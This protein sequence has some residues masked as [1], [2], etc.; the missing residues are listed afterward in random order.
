MTPAVCTEIFMEFMKQILYLRGQIPTS[1]EQLQKFHAR[2]QGKSRL[3]SKELKVFHLIKTVNEC[4]ESLQKIFESHYQNRLHSESPDH[5]SDADSMND[6]E[7]IESIDIAVLFGKSYM[8][9]LE[10]Y[11]LRFFLN[12]ADHEDKASEL[13][14]KMKRKIRRVVGRDLLDLADLFESDL[15]KTECRVMANVNRSASDQGLVDLDFMPKHNVLFRKNKKQTVIRINVVNK[16]ISRWLIQSVTAPN[17]GSNK[18]NDASSLQIHDIESLLNGATQQDES[19]NEDD[20]ENEDGPDRRL[21]YL[22]A[23]KFKAI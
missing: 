7:C 12:S 6:T 4:A 10:V 15:P 9:P 8:K 1:F 22:S 5:K 11:S 17:D 23:F 21:W 3:K 14:D 20:D 18:E 2:N 13:N 16:A 19:G